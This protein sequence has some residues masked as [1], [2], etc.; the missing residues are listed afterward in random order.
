VLYSSHVLDLV[1]KVCD[2]VVVL[3]R[4][5]VV[6]HDSV[7]NLRRL[8]ASGSLEDVFS[9]LVRHDDP[10]QMAADIVDVVIG[11]A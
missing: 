8:Q 10:E 5:R 1:E 7:E 3:H 11:H 2:R 4:G 9:Q 6:A